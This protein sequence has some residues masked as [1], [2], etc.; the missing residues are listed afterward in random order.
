MIE[1]MFQYAEQKYGRKKPQRIQ[2]EEK[3]SPMEDYELYLKSLN[4]KVK[5]ANDKIAII[6]KQKRVCII[7]CQIIVISF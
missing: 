1:G 3:R 2:V 5:S 4:I 7:L 6:M